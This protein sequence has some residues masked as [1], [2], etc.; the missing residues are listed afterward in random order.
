[1][2]CFKIPKLQEVFPTDE[3]MKTAA[4]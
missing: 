1:M 2:L 4:T 3:T